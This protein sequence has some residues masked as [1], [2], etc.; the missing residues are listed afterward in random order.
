MLGRRPLAAEAHCIKIQAAYRGW[1]VRRLVLHDVRDAFA[2]IV[3]ELE[4]DSLTHLLLQCDATTI[5]WPSTRLCYPRFTA[6]LV[7]SCPVRA[8]TRAIEP[9]HDMDETSRE[10]MVETP[11]EAL[12]ASLPVEPPMRLMK[13]PPYLAD[14]F[15]AMTSTIVRVR[16][17]EPAI[18]S[19][20]VHLVHAS[21][22]ASISPSCDRQHNM[23]QVVESSWS[24]HALL[25]MDPLRIQD[26]LQ[27]AKD[28]LRERIEFLRARA[29]ASQLSS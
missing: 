25:Q 7:T 6:G 26:E 8:T 21:Q 9:L 1:R 2:Q 15:S 22:P 20:P 4:T 27:W 24:V 18:E 16:K 28:A 3:R 10:P 12:A 17:E 29:A 23:K 5:A 14:T 11:P 13:A 19:T